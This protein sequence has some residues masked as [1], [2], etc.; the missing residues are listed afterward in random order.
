VRR[1]WDRKQIDPA[2][3]GYLALIDEQDSDD[4]D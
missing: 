1:E 4:I 3:A 2:L